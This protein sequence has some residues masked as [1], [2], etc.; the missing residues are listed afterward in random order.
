MALTA[1]WPLEMRRN[2]SARASMPEA[3]LRSFSPTTPAERGLIATTVIL[4]P[5]ENQ[6]P[7]VGGFSVLF[8]LF[9]VIAVYVAL[10]RL[11]NLDRVWMHPVFAATFLFLLVT[12]AL[13]FTS[14][15]PMYRDLARFALAVCGA[16]L[17]ACL[18]RDRAA[19]RMALYGYLCSGLVLSSLLYLTSY[20]I[21][22]QATVGGFQDATDLR[23]ET[24]RESPIQANLNS[25]ALLTAQAGVIA[26]GLGLASRGRPSVVFLGIAGFC[27]LSSML[28]MSRGGLAI[29]ALSSAT[30]LFAHGLKRARTLL[31]VGLLTSGLLG[32]MP[33]A[34]FSR[35]SFSTEK[36]DSRLE[37]RASL[38]VGALNTLP[39]YVLSG[40]GA[41][42]FYQKWGFEKG[43]VRG[44]HR[45]K[46]V[47]VHNS[48]LQIMINWG[49]IGLLM[50]LTIVWQAYRCLPQKY[51]NDG[52]ALGLLGLA[53]SCLLWAV[54]S[55][56]FYDKSFTLALG[57]LAGAHRWIWPQAFARELRESNST[58]IP[59][60][61][62]TQH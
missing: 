62:P 43:F 46:V 22:S 3:V 26:L 55:H 60:I 12:G 48:F 23:A 10:N 1:N 47:A 4:L 44:H 16:V 21:L 34:I 42:N 19:L 40:V 38:Y 14:P 15:L 58:L 18:C 45:L 37:A 32:A 27:I 7:A 25:L 31:L 51:G 52:L 61:A 6:I 53:T 39:E 13:E 54:V 29:A 56:N 9:G 35:M 5:I 30:V 17:L 20:D 33:D 8:L 28:T 41:G 11:V 57:M 49:L 59:R 24:F 50:Y 2:E 36:Q